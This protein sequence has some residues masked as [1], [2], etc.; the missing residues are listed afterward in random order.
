VTRALASRLLGAGAFV[1][2]MVVLAGDAMID[3]MLPLLGAGFA[4]VAPELELR[5]LARRP[6]GATEA[7]VAE[8]SIARPVTVAGRV[9]RPDPRGTAWSST[10]AGHVLLMPALVAVLVLGWPAAGTRE[11]AA[12]LGIA[13]LGLPA[14]IALDVPVVLASGVWDLFPGAATRAGLTGVWAAFMD[15]GGRFAVAVLLGAAAVAAGRR[16]PG[17]R[18]PGL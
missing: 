14:L 10:P 2:A 6:A 1:L 4:G 5:T 3:G 15:G 13:A 16:F 11:W 12:R 9:Y 8:V 18:P 17:R 7:L